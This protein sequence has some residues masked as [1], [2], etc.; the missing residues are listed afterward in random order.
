MS[1]VAVL[2]TFSVAAASV[3]RH[4]RSIESG[5]YYAADPQ[6]V[7]PVEQGGENG[8]SYRGLVSTTVSG[9][10]CRNWL[11]IN[12][13]K[14]DDVV[15]PTSDIEEDNVMK[16]GNGLGNHNYCRNPDSSSKK[17]W[18]FTNNP[19]KPFEDCAI[20]ECPKLSYQSA[21]QR[22]AHTMKTAMSVPNCGAADCLFGS[23]ETTGDTT[24]KFLQATQ[25]RRMKD[26]RPCSC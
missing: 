26:G 4:D 23:T 7:L 3:I 19:K 16:W 22:M 24:V 13:W 18:C 12:P 8:R 21:A 2:V 6:D 14:F 1:R 5:C 11:D 20:P 9:S 10:S 17:P 15:K 25:T